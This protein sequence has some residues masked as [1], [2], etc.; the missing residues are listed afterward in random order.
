MRGRAGCTILLTLA[1]GVP[2]A[3][4]AENHPLNLIRIMPA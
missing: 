1:I 3:W 2:S 4:A